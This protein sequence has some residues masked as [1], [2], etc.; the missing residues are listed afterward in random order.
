MNVANH[1]AYNYSAKPTDSTLSP[2]IIK[3]TCVGQLSRFSALP[4]DTIQFGKWSAEQKRQLALSKMTEPEFLELYEKLAR[5][6][7]TP[8]VQEGVT[9]T[10]KIIFKHAIVRLDYVMDVAF[11]DRVIEIVD[12]ITDASE[13]D[14][15]MDAC[16]KARYRIAKEKSMA[17]MIADHIL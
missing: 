9:Y 14:S 13:V 16:I 17:A 1:L 10:E 7:D 8:V 11:V 4:Q 2:A 3:K 6:Y 15:L 12:L 5:Q